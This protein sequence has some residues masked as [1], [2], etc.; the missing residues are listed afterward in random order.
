MRKIFPDLNSDSACLQL[1]KPDETKICSSILFHK[2]QIIIPHKK[3]FSI[4]NAHD[5]EKVY[6]VL[7]WR[8]LSCFKGKKRKTITREKKKFMMFFFKVQVFSKYTTFL[9]QMILF[10]F[11]SFLKRK[12]NKNSFFH[13]GH[14]TTLPKEITSQRITKMK[15]K[16]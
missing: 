16:T 13:N 11:R 4:P 1:K 2:Q 9:P 14:N 7:V 15:K 8:T 3:M 10:N 5:T 6:R 12:I